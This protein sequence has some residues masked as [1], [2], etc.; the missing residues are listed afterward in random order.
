MG[1][2]KKR[3]G[4]PD[5]RRR[6]EARLSWEAIAKQIAAQQKSTEL[7]DGLTFREIS[8]IVGIC[9][10]SLRKMLWFAVANGMV[11]VSKAQRPNIL[12]ELK[13]VPVYRLVS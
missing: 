8:E 2:P 3:R 13:S 11:E 1:S 10:P 5:A 12:G 9:D 7:A 4:R 6:D